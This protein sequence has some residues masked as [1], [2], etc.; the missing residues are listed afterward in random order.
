M[1]LSPIAFTRKVR[2]SGRSQT[3]VPLA[4]N[5]TRS[6]SPAVAGM[7]EYDATGGESRT[8]AVV[9]SARTRAA[10]VG[11][12]AETFARSGRICC[13][14]HMWNDSSGTGAFIEP[15]NG[16]RTASAPALT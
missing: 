10:L 2:M 16:D 7:A 5:L 15:P 12:A 6:P 1:D 14:C 9:V 8:A 13:I 4:F 11:R 3:V